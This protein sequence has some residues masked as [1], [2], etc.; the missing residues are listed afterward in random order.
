MIVLFKK[1]AWLWPWRL[2]P[3]CPTVDK[4]DMPYTYRRREAGKEAGGKMWHPRGKLFWVG[5]GKK[6][7]KKRKRKERK[8]GGMYF[9]MERKRE[10]KERERERD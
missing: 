3:R 7:K 9:L 6:R 4:G 5:G 8:R 2:E 10:K 1:M